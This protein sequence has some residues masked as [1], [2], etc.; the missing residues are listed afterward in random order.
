MHKKFLKIFKC[1]YSNKNL[2]LDITKEKEDII[3]DGYLYTDD[4]KYKYPIINGIPRFV[5]SNNYSK[6][7][8]WQW[9]KWSKVQFEE[10]NIGKPMQNHT[11]EM[12]NA[13]TEMNYSNLS[14]D[15]ILE[16]GCGSGRF[17]D[18]LKNKNCTI[19]G[20]DNSESID[21]TYKNLENVDKTKLLLVQC[22]TYNL[23]F[24][25]SSFN[26]IYS[27]GVLH[28]TPNPTKIINNIFKILKSKGSFSLTVYNKNSYY[29]LPNVNMWRKFFNFLHP[30]LG[31][32]PALIYSYFTVIFLRP[33]TRLNKIFD[34]LIRIPFPFCNEKDFKWS[35]LD[36]FD[37]VT[38]KY[39]NT[40]ETYEVYNWLKNNNFTNIVPTNWGSC[41]FKGQKD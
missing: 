13:I 30:F 27:I 1:P 41:S 6:S 34:I 15:Y 7:F 5:D 22:D 25:D 20:I 17:L 14:N 36:T 8:G 10:N 16:I 40:Y 21:V 35:L 18:I 9:K 24:K 19:I 33:I 26:H 2:L 23:P 12:F 39:Q 28:H 3:L 31:F 11:T 32:Y 37:S 29:S 4:T 38:P